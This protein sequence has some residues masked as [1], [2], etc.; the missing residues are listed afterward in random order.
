MMQYLRELQDVYR[1]KCVDAVLQ[2]NRRISLI[3][4]GQ[5][6]ISEPR[7]TK[8]P[9][10][11]K[12]PQPQCPGLKTNYLCTAMTAQEAVYYISR[13]KP[14]KIAVLNC[15]SALRP[16]G[17]LSNPPSGKMAYHLKTQE[18]SLVIST[19]TAWDV[20]LKQRYPMHE[21]DVYYIAGVHL[22]LEE[23]LIE[24]DMMVAPAPNMK[25]DRMKAELSRKSFATIIDEHMTTMLYNHL[26]TAHQN[27]C[28]H[29]VLCGWGIGVFAPEGALSYKDS[30]CRA[31]A[32][33]MFNLVSNREC[34]GGYFET[35]V[36]ACPGN[37]TAFSTQIQESIDN[38]CMQ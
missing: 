24:Y 33:M 10:H 8:I 17:Q 6:I 27:G 37:W 1:T 30:Y 32:N 5:G 7:V 13:S 20:M 11:V 2:T 31:I 35:I 29:V 34:L 12:L 23:N 18:E 25:G 38:L 3:L 19:P 15:A 28:R 26:V 14:G 16:G 9:R 21:I 36:F 22:L 4:I